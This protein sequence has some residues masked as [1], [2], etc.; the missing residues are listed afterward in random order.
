MWLLWVASLLPIA[1]TAATWHVLSRAGAAQADVH[2]KQLLHH[3]RCD[4]CLTAAAL[5]GGI[6][7]GQLPF[8]PHYVGHHEAPQA[9]SSDVWSALATW[10]YR[11]RAPPSARH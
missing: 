1:Q 11:S 10:A 9:I 8:S 4:F 2:D 3:T 6:L 5:S 7:P